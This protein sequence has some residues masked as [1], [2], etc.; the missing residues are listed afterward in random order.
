MNFRVIRYA[1]RPVFIRGMFEAIVEQRSVNYM[2]NGTLQAGNYPSSKILCRQTGEGGLPIWIYPG[3]WEKK[4]QSLEW[5]KSH[6]KI[7]Y[8]ARKLRELENTSGV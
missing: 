5:L 6:Y 8:A 1:L 7:Q 4:E 2:Y 3:D